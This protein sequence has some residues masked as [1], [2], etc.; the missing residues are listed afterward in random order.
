MNP[1]NTAPSDVEANNIPKE[2]KIFNTYWLLKSGIEREF[3]NPMDPRKFDTYKKNK[4]RNKENI[5]THMRDIRSE[6][7]EEWSGVTD[8]MIDTEATDANISEQI[9]RMSQDLV[10]KRK[11]IYDRSIELFPSISDSEREIL[12]GEI[13]GY[14]E[15]ELHNFMTRNSALRKMIY[16]V[17]PWLRG[18]S[19][20]E[21]KDFDAIFHDKDNYFD[22]TEQR[23]LEKIFHDYY[24]FDRI[25]DWEDIDFILWKYSATTVSDI[26]RKEILTVLGV[27]LT[28]KDAIG[29]NLIDETF[30]E[31]FS[32]KWFEELY[33]QLDTPAKK[34][35]I[36][37]L[38]YNTSY[39][40]PAADFSENSLGVI[41]SQK[42]QRR[43][44]AEQVFRSV[45]MDMPEEQEVNKKRNTD[46]VV[47]RIT[48]RKKKEAEEAN[49]EFREID[50]D[51]Y[52][53]VIEEL[54][55]SSQNSP[56]KPSRIENI[57]N[58]KKNG[59][60][61]QFTHTDGSTQYVRV[62]AGR[63]PDGSPCESMD[64]TENCVKLEGF[65]V[66][67]N[68]LWSPQPFNSSYETF[69]SFLL[70][71][72]GVRILTAEEFENKLTSNMSEVGEWSDKIYD[73]RTIETDPVTAVNISSK[74]DLIDSEG[75][76]F[77]FEKWTS[78]RAPVSDK[79]GKRQNEDGIWTIKNIHPANNTIDLIDPWGNNSENGLPLD[80]VY[81]VILQNAQG[82]KRVSKIQDDTELVKQLGKFGV[83]G[84]KDGNLLIKSK[85]SHG[86][87]EEK[88]ITC[89]SN[90]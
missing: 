11:R 15:N 45:A 69:L 61:I 17:F 64:G 39:L 50:Y 53:E 33:D 26:R 35:F 37:G 65:N 66:I 20:S 12:R 1:P 32:Q 31:N 55:I 71:S 60:V 42:S 90:E 89:F 36:R 3:G 6:N 59:A 25:P 47:A 74:L 51:L 81:A 24:Q 63:N 70:A 46:P 22:Q 9:L 54:K 48:E 7:K 62:V 27:T 44:L 4:E 86:K 13:A 10:F 56:G 75:S 52:D 14:N 2:T 28:I 57:D 38:S 76:K 29:F 49:Q 82:F 43:K 8:T 34:S 21:H 40:I 16:G 58:L 23:R 79:D 83:D 87:E 85:D 77:W 80:Q 67:E 19:P 72:Q 88:N 30:L 5:R 18:A 84:I 41:L 68:R 78:F 73:A